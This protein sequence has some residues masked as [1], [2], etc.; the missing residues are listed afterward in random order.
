MSNSKYAQ[1]RAFQFCSEIQQLLPCSANSDGSC[2]KLD[3]CYRAGE[4]GIICEIIH[5]TDR[6]RVVD[7]GQSVQFFDQP[8]KFFD[9]SVQFFANYGA[10]GASKGQLHAAWCP[11][12]GVSAGKKSPEHL[13]L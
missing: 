2:C 3:E 9:E 5:D 13:E 1:P 7:D 8:V 12:S 10:T 4:Q 6:Q 11:D